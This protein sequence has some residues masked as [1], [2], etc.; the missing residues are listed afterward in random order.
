MAAYKSGIEQRAANNI[1][2]LIK[3][4]DEL[5]LIINFVIPRT[6]NPM[7]NS[8]IDTYVN[9]SLPIINYISLI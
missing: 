8:V 2:S 4:K 3:K 6:L 5:L 9:L 7:R 1:I